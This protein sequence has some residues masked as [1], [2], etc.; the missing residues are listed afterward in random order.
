MIQNSPRVAALQ[1]F[2]STPGAAAPDLTFTAAR[3]FPPLSVWLNAQVKEKQ[4][5]QL[6]G[7]I[8]RKGSVKN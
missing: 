6:F 1:L 4:P 3:P 2:H 5:C 7:D 8:S